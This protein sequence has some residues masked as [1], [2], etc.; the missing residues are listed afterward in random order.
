MATEK[1][2]KPEVKPELPKAEGKLETV[3]RKAVQITTAT[4]T[5]GRIIL[6]ALCND[7]TIWWRDA[8]A[9]YGDWTQIKS[10]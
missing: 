1:E 8:M 2:T 5:T 10:L 3:K 6:T 9:D 4:T 7:G